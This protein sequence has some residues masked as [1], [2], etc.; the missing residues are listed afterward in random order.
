MLTSSFGRRPFGRRPNSTL[1]SDLVL[2]NTIERVKYPI[3]LFLVS[4][5]KLQYD[6]TNFVVVTTLLFSIRVFTA[7]PQTEKNQ[8]SNQYRELE[9]Q[10]QRTFFKV[11]TVQKSRPFFSAH[12]QSSRRNKPKG[13]GRERRQQTIPI[14][15]VKMYDSIDNDE[16]NALLPGS[17]SSRSIENKYASRKG[18]MINRIFVILLLAGVVA[19]SIWLESFQTRMFLQ[20]STEEEKIKILEDTVQAQGMIIA[21]FNESVTNADVIGKLETMETRWDSERIDLFDELNQ[22]KLYVS[23]ELNST[24]VELDETV[25]IARAEIHEQV[26]SVKKNFDQYVVKTEDRF[27]MENDFMKYQVAGTFTILSCLISMWHMGSH[28]R[29]MNQPAIQRKILAILWM[30]PIYVSSNAKRVCRNNFGSFPRKMS[31]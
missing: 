2:Y 15:N 11:D 21:R 18:V 3:V 13:S 14:N 25:K 27:S 4:V 6:H 26:D 16:S 10:T 12:I 20:L 22:T 19:V 1:N 7:F 23:E 30:C 9:T 5:R 28:T 8:S 31:V 17:E 29:K 24:M